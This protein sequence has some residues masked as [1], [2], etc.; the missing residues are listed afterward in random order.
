MRYTR[1]WN[2]SWRYHTA[3]HNKLDDCRLEYLQLFG[4]SVEQIKKCK[5]KANVGNPSAIKMG[6][7]IKHVII[8]NSVEF[9]IFNSFARIQLI[10]PILLLDQHT[11][12]NYKLYSARILGILSLK[13]EDSGT[14]LMEPMEGKKSL[15]NTAKRRVMS[16][17]LVQIERLRVYQS[18]S[19][20]SAF[21]S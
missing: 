13:N 8:W 9:I 5:E 6:L 17:A 15:N 19:G 4:T 16:L 2:H 1:G 18:Y 20:E 7:T 12:K 3:L 14:D 10:L 11:V 21:V